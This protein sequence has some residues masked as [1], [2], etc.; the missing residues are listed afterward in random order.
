VANVNNADFD[1]VAPFDGFRKP[2]AAREASRRRW[3]D[4]LPEISVLGGR[5]GP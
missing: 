2:G 1:R 3:L 4:G 5:S